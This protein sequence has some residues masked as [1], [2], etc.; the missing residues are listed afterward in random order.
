MAPTDPKRNGSG[1]DWSTASR[2]ADDP[3]QSPGLQ[4]WRQFLAWQR[5]VN[6]LLQPLG[7]TQPQFSILASVA[8]LASHRAEAEPRGEVSQQAVA[9]FT[10]MDRMLVSQIVR[11]LEAAGLVRRRPSA[12]D[13]RAF[14]LSP[15]AKGSRCLTRA[16]PLVEDHDVAF[17]AKGVPQPSGV[18]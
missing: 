9:D 12:H 17:F 13:G 15:T 6:A 7:I 1:L 14:A 3:S 16:L 11:R 4:L 10:G 2:Y 18:R 5:S 8:W